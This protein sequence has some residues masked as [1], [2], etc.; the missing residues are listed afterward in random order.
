MLDILASP[1]KGLR[2]LAGMGD[3]GVTSAEY[4][5]LASLIAVVIAGAVGLLGNHV[6]IFFSQ[7]AGAF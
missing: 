2:W 3:R 5:M 4:A 7:I 6:N 1:R